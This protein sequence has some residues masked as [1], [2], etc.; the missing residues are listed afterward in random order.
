MKVFTIK[1]RKINKI[2][3]HKSF[4]MARWKKHASKCQVE[5]KPMRNTHLVMGNYQLDK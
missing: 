1:I 3:A 2:I 4:I 5:S